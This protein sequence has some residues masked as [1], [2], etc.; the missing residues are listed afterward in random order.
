MQ[1]LS[2]KTLRLSEE[3]VAMTLRLDPEVTSAELSQDS[4]KTLVHGFRLNSSKTEK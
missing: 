4:T 1:G 2:G 3:R